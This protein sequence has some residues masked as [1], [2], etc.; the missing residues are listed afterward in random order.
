MEYFA[1][2][3]NQNYKCKISGT[4]ELNPGV[5][6]AGVRKRR[7]ATVKKTRNTTPRFKALD[8]NILLKVFFILTDKFKY[9]IIFIC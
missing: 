8:P 9:K 4:S 7:K 1:S 3:K 5:G 6:P 2:Q